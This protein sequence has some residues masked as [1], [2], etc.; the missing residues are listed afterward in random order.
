MN[1]RRVRLVRGVSP[2]PGQAQSLDTVPVRVSDTSYG[3]ED[4][5]VLFT[6]E[7]AT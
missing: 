4:A 1:P 2:K 6:N 3:A 5:A 7:V